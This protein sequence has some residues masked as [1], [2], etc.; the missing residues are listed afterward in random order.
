MPAK[1][2][3]SPDTT[4]LDCAGLN[5][6]NFKD[7]AATNAAKHKLAVTKLPHAITGRFAVGTQA[8]CDKWDAWTLKVR[9]A[10]SLESR[11]FLRKAGPSPTW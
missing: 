5:W 3:P 2:P 8:A 4:N 11:V 1:M 10:V 6:F 9:K 7:H